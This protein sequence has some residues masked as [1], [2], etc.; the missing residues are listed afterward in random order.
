MA[1]AMLE[2]GAD[3]RYIQ[4]ILGHSCLSTTEIYTQVTIGKL[5]QVHSLTH[6][7]TQEDSLPEMDVQTHMKLPREWN[8]PEKTPTAD[9]LSDYTPGNKDLLTL[10]EKFIQW[11]T[12]HNY[13]PHTI[14]SNRF[15]LGNF[16]KWCHS[17]E[18]YSVNHITKS[19]IESFEN[20]L[21]HLKNLKNGK[22][23]SVSSRAGRLN[24]LLLFF[25]WLTDH[26]YIRHNPTCNVD[27]PKLPKRLPRQV[28][29]Y[30]EVEKILHQPD[31]STPLGVRDRAVLETLYSTGIRRQEVVGLEVQDIDLDNGTILIKYSKNKRDRVVPIGE[32][33]IAWLEKYLTQVRPMLA[34]AEEQAYLFLNYYGRRFN[35]NG[36]S[37]LL[38][39]YI[40]A[41]DI[42]KKGSCHMFRHA[43]ATHML[44]NGADVR[45][46]HETP[47]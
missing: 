22:L 38:N 21:L 9:S 45:Y 30:E 16:I 18:I 33:A 28:L 35:I 40:K 17:K 43:M 47:T 1:T 36:F 31:I 12:V 15:Y 8:F 11:M 5:K 42:G 13:S 14:A 26:E 24:S 44:E 37:N 41:A 39:E 25:R 34:S 6:P 29:T 32:R 3:I 19:L 23:L 7:A 27:L 46:I 2:N 20:H 4:E 10:G